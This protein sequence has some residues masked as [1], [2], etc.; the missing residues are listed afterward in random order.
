MTAITNRFWEGAE[1]I[2][3]QYTTAGKAVASLPE[4][5]GEAAMVH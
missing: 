2:S 5:A 1:L 4:P 3:T